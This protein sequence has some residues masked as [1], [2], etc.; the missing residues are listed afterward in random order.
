MDGDKNQHV[1]LVIVIILLLL[2]LFT[3]K[4][5]KFTQEDAQLGIDSV[6]DNSV[7]YPYMESSIG[8]NMVS[9]PNMETDMTNM[10]DYRK[11]PRLFYLASGELVQN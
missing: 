5:E 9:Y 1:I 11:K 6:G 2:W 8:D 3:S 10:N 4:T 7:S